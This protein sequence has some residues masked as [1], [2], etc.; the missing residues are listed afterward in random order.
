MQAFQRDLK[1]FEKLNAQ[2]LGVSADSI[3]THEEFSS[4]N[5]LQYPLV[6][7]EGGD[8]RKLYAPGRVTYIIDKAGVIRFIQQGV[9]D[10][11]ELLEE[12]AKLPR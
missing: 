11:T 5:G 6:A 3:A 4:K 12:L 1:N 10:N 2:V 7:D 8:V 9:P